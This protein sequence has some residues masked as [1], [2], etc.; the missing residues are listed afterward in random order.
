MAEL[1]SIPQLSYRK[2]AL[3]SDADL[4]CELRAIAQYDEINGGFIWTNVR[5]FRQ[6]Y[7]IGRKAGGSDG[8][9]Y[10]S[11]NIAGHKFKVHRLVWLWHKGQ[12]PNGMI[13]HANG[14]K[15]DNRIENLRE[16]TTAENVMNR[17]R[18][19]DLSTGVSSDS[20]GKFKARIQTADG[21]KVY[22]GTFNTEIEAAAA[23]AG[24][25]VMLHGEYAVSK[26]V[27]E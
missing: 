13:D 22:L 9:G 10:E 5:Y 2:S 17:L 3:P 19:G 16:A 24:A 7:L 18:G 6:K 27:S 26:R 23:Y 21:V 4:L 1:N 25:S 15:L 8:R 20:N 12:F 14:N 11:M